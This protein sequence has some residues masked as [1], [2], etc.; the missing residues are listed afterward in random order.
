MTLDEFIRLRIDGT[1][2]PRNAYVKE[3]GFRSCYVRVTRRYVK[4]RMYEPVLDL[5]NIEAESPGKGVFTA[6]VARLRKDWPTL[7]L[8]VESVLNP[9]FEKKLLEMGF[10]CVGPEAPR[11]FWMPSSAANPKKGG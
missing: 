10:E 6:L 3:Q 7:S 1:T 8:Y 9:R 11:N 2:W 4:G 5:A